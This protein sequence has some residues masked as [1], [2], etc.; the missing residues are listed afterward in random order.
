MPLGKNEQN[1]TKEELCV[2]T[3]IT[4]RL[5]LLP[6][7]KEEGITAQCLSFTRAYF[8]LPSGKDIKKVSILILR[9]RPQPNS[10]DLRNNTL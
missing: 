4:P 10:T 8:K 9:M 6:N 7:R 5:Q 2:F 3:R 1:Y